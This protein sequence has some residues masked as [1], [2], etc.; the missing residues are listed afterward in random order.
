MQLKNDPSYRIVKSNVTT[1][2]IDGN[3]AQGYIFEQNKL[4]DTLL[5]GFL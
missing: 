3:E 1:Y 5:G 2:N 4:D